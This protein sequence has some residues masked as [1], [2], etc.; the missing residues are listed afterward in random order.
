MFFKNKFK[1]DGSQLGGASQ[2]Q[3]FP[4]QQPPLPSM[5]FSQQRDLVEQ[6]L[7]NLMLSQ[8]SEAA[9]KHWMI[10]Q[11]INQCWLRSA[12]GFYNIKN[13]LNSF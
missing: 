4:F 12:K 6:Q 11:I 9:R 1:K 5:Q 2:S 10:W 7:Q 8:Q 13:F 3:Q